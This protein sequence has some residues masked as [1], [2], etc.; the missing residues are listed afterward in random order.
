[1]E[2]AVA[3]VSR[4]VGAAGGDRFAAACGVGAQYGASS[5]R[6]S[7]RLGGDRPVGIPTCAIGGAA[8][9]ANPS[10][11]RRA[12]GDT[13][14]SSRCCCVS[15]SRETSY[16]GGGDG[17]LV[18]PPVRAAPVLSSSTCHAAGDQRFARGGRATAAAVVRISAAVGWTSGAAVRTSGPVVRT[19]R[20]AAVR[21]SNAVVRTSPTPAR[22]SSDVVSGTSRQVVDSRSRG[23]RPRPGEGERLLRTSANSKPRGSSKEGLVLEKGGG[24]CRRRS[25]RRPPRFRRLRGICSLSLSYLVGGCPACCALCSRPAAVSPRVP[26]GADGFFFFTTL[27]STWLGRKLRRNKKRITIEPIWRENGSLVGEGGGGGGGGG[28]QTPFHSDAQ[29]QFHSDAQREGKGEVLLSPLL[30]PLDRRSHVLASRDGPRPKP[31][32]AW[33][34]LPHLLLSSCPRSDR[35]PPPLSRSSSALSWRSRTASWRGRWRGQRRNSMIAKA[36]VEIASAID[37]INNLGLDTLTFLV[38]AVLVIP[39]FKRMNVSPVLGFLLSGLVLNHFG[40]FRNVAD[41]EALSELGILFLLFEMGLEL[42]LGRLK[43]LAKFAFGMGLL[44]VVT[45]TL[46]FTFFELPPYSALGTK[47]LEWAFHSRHDLVNIRTI[48]EAVVIGAALSL[49]SSAFVL[50]LLAEKGELPTRFGSATLGILLLQDIAVVPLLVILPI[51]E[52][53]QFSGGS[54]ELFLTLGVAS[55]KGLLGLGLLLLGGKLILRRVFELVAS[56]RSPEAFVA[57]CLLTV[58]GTSLITQRLGFSDTLGAFLAG[59]LLAGTNFRT[60]VEADIRP[61]RGLLL[62]LFF[63]TTGT[64]IDIELLVREWP[65]VLALLAGLIA[66]KTAIITALGPRFGLTWGESV[67]TAFLLSQGGEFAFVVFSLANQLGVLPLE[68]NRLLIIVVVLSMALTPLLNEAGR[69]AAAYVEKRMVD[70]EGEGEEERRT[71]LGGGGVDLADDYEM[72][73]PVVIIGFGQ[74]GQILANFLST[75]LATWSNSENVAWPYV[76]FDLEP[77]RV[78]TA[79]SLGFPVFYGD[80]SRPEVLLTAGINTPRALMVMYKGRERAVEAVERLRLA[81]PTVP[82]YAR[83]LDLDHLTEL[84]LAGATDVVPEN[85]ETSLRLGS[86]LLEKLGVMSDDVTFLRRVLRDSL[87]K[88]AKEFT[89]TDSPRGESQDWKD[90]ILIRPSS[91]SSSSSSSTTTSGVANEEEETANEEEAAANEEE[92]ANEA[93][94][95]VADVGSAVT[96]ETVTLAPDDARAEPDDGG[97]DQAM[98]KGTAATT[99]DGGD[100]R[101][102]SMISQTAVERRTEGEVD[103]SGDASTE[104]GA[105]GPGVGGSPPAPFPQVISSPM[106]IDYS[107]P[108]RDAVAGIWMSG[109]GGGK[110]RQQE[111]D[112]P[113]VGNLISG[114]AGEEANDEGGTKEEEEQE[115][116]ESPVL[117]TEFDPDLPMRHDRD[118][119]PVFPSASGEL[120]AADDPIRGNTPQEDITYA[121]DDPAANT[122]RTPTP[123]LSSSDPEMSSLAGGARQPP[124][125]RD[126]S[127][128]P[129]SSTSGSEL[130]EGGY[131]ERSMIDGRTAKKEEESAAILTGREPDGDDD[132]DGDGPNGCLTED[133]LSSSSSHVRD[134]GDGERGGALGAHAIDEGALEELVSNRDAVE[135]NPPGLDNDVGAVLLSSVPEG[136]DGGDDRTFGSSVVIVETLDLP[137]S[138]RLK[139]VTL[140]PLVAEEDDVT[141]VEALDESIP[142]IKVFDVSDPDIVSGEGD[143]I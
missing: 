134:G 51:L 58:T 27:T 93:A 66:M 137:D 60:Q 87:E 127:T 46:A 130:G 29:R 34:D 109:E 71:S 26:L 6:F 141:D 139:G 104:E 114:E 80:G 91:S 112:S 92:A 39:T 75:P 73:E 16:R 121:P 77:K 105:M 138:M 36:G 31:A 35:S 30:P 135:L 108:E 72:G 131:Y 113:V 57:L 126:S 25:L 102:G 10:T 116:E 2:G 59:A 49:S 12:R 68:L 103:P 55:L 33:T 1:M 13:W 19:A 43:A 67:R 3:S 70:K 82:I 64:S 100:T 4:C 81:Y 48:D 9:I 143:G 37:V 85:T 133:A 120:P 122:S 79:R 110:G 65:N 86:A 124:D 98:V 125:V 99:A 129:S 90:V 106:S 76:A 119:L 74:L 94:Q 15:H 56:S 47:L 78:K 62:G 123:M 136:E 96:F 97:N 11:E 5:D 7:C 38:T 95:R 41:I 28:R 63:V 101:G 17:D 128:V 24:D 8:V 61:F 115:E 45:T 140:C 132:G 23:P 117:P 42:S 54:S 88:R 52:S 50:Q 21:S 111:D 20:E 53:G 44:Q 32:A 18:S 142:Y 84:K 69:I 118:P 14:P 40:W 89:R 22:S 107:S 83:A